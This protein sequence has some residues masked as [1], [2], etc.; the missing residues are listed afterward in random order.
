VRMRASSGMNV[1]PAFFL[2][3]FSYALG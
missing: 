1:L 2:A 3:T